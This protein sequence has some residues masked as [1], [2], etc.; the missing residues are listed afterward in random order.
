[1]LKAVID[2]HGASSETN[3]LLGRVYKDCWEE[4]LKAGNDFEAVGW[5]DKAI[6][7][8]LAGFE[9]DWRDAYPGINAVT[10]MELADPPDPRR[11]ELVQVVTYAVKRRIARGKPDYWDHATLVEASV[12]AENKADA[13]KAAAAALP[14]VREKW[15]PGTTANNLRL[16]REAR[17]RQGKVVDWADK[18]EQ[19]LLAKAG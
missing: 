15:E 3:G 5:L 12:L 7:V 14:L 4:A 11:L 19:A 13:N 6:E 10:L 16:I 2:S 1:V 9:A 17:A 18:I 8:Y